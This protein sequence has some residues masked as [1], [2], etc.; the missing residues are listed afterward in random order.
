[1]MFLHAIIANYP[2]PYMNTSVVIYIVLLP[3]VVPIV[4]ALVAVVVPVVPVPVLV[5][6]V[7]ITALVPA[8]I[9]SFN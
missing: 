4:P 3:E 7:M 9:S 2:T 5:A 6:V 1:M 8:T